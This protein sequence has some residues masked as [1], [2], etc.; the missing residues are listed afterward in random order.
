MSGLLTPRPGTTAWLVRHE[1]RLGWRTLGGNKATLSLALLVITNIGLHVGAWYVMR[2]WDA[3]ALPPMA[4]YILGAAAWFVILLMLSQAIAASVLAL[5]DRGDLDLLLTS[6]LPTQAVFMARGLGIAANVSV[7]YLFLLAP[8]ADVGLVTGHPGLLAIYPTVLALA[9][10]VSSIGLWLTLG[11]VRALGARRART[12][13]QVLGSLVGAAMFLLSQASNALGRDN[14]RHVFAQLARWAQPGGPLAVDSALWWPS[15]ALLGDPVPL[16]A[17]AG[18][19][20]L[21]FLAVVRLA[22]RRFLAGTQESV[23]GSARRT[24][25]AP[26]AGSARFRGGLWRIVLVKEWRLIVRDPQV[27]SQTL[28]QLVYMTPMM[29]VIGRSAN[30]LTPLLVPAVVYLASSLA[31]NI[32]WITVA[33]EESPELLGTSPV[34]MSQLRW[35]KILAALLPVWVLVSPLAAWLAWAAPAQALV[36]VA[37]LLGSTLTI[38][39]SQVWYPRQGK[40]GD[41]K[42]RAQGNGGLGLIELLAVAS[43]AWLAWCLGAALAWAPAAL[44]AAAASSGAIWLLGRAPRASDAAGQT[45]ASGRRA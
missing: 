3:G 17:I 39:A 16:L 14:V 4:T 20:V 11:L 24:A 27:I 42:K 5:F 10:A 35:I 8:V 18:V 30:A 34:P 21:L 25:D 13:A 45:V 9:L 12:V 2:G 41:L 28:M 36:F 38:G 23:D 31:T 1:L 43:W 6:P 44:G 19:G 15:R 26:R 7:L 32:A 33:A 37:C 29:F 22:H 40:R